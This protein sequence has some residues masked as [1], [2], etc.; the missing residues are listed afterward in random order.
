M[1]VSVIVPAHNARQY[2]PR[3]I[4]S[5]LNQTFQDF[6]IIIVDDG[7]TDMT[8]QIGQELARTRPGRVAY[9]YQDNQGPGAARNTGIKAAGGEYIAFIDADDLWLPTKLEKQAAILD[10]RPDV[11]LVYTDL[12]FFNHRD[13]IVGH[14]S[15]RKYPLPRGST[16]LF[17]F[18]RYFMVTSTVMA[19]KSLI[20]RNGPFREDIRV[21]EDYD[22]FMR[23][24]TLA[25]AEPVNEEL[26]GKRYR[27]DSLSN[28]DY[29]VNNKN[30]ILI[31]GEFIRKNPAFFKKHRRVLTRI[32]G[33]RTFSLGYWAMRG[34]RKSLALPYLVKAMGYEP[35]F[36][37]VKCMLQLAIPFSLVRLARMI[38][39][40]PEKTVKQG[41]GEDTE[42][43]EFNESVP[44]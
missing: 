27:K 36:K 6:E 5:I 42:P 28:L 30:D 34:G 12:F 38:V 10:R 1:K 17:F 26:L 32:M 31:Y 13:K 21:G 35:S 8:G 25:S 16:T 18:F 24:S 9:I 22:F 4:E 2:L 23:L 14:G 43:K 7:S 33:R 3:T 19:R 40:G 41:A 44:V 20:R 29:V 15:L 39:R 37:T 11:G